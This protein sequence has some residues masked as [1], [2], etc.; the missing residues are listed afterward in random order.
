M[1]TFVYNKQIRIL[2]G[3]QNRHDFARIRGD[4]V[5]IRIL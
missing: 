2:V 5:E 3:G 4:I 1:Q